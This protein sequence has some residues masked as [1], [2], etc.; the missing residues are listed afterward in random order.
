MLRPVHLCP[1]PPNL[2]PNT[3]TPKSEVPCSRA[4]NLADLFLSLKVML[5]REALEPPSP[6]LSPEE[7][8][9]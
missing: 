2:N 3:L 9:P 1:L 8:W 6:S 4:N 7:L 5:R